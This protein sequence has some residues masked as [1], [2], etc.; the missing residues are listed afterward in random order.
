[1]AGPASP[2]LS[3]GQL[4]TLAELGEERTADVG[5]VLFRVS[6]RTY[7]FIERLPLRFL[8]FFLG[9]APCTEWL[10]DTVARH[11]NGFILTG[12]AVGADNLLETSVPGVRAAV[13]VLSGSTKRCATAVGEGAMAVQFVH[14]QL[15]APNPAGMVST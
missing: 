10:D 9:A 7:P 6:D 3:A 4:E 14:G 1:L 2:T 13:D 5:D 15:A 8:F 12:S 11:E